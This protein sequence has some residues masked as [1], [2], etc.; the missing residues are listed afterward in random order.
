MPRSLASKL[1]ALV[2]AAT[3]AG[4][5]AVAP[6]VAR[7]AAA[8]DC[9]TYYCATAFVLFSGNGTGH[10]V[11]D[12]G[13]IDCYKTGPSST[14]GTCTYQ[15]YWIGQSS[16]RLA[17]NFTRTATANSE[18]CY[19][20]TTT[21]GEPGGSNTIP[22]SLARNDY[23]SVPTTFALANVMTMNVTLTGD[24][25]GTATSSPSGINCHLASGTMSG[26]C[27][28]TWYF[29]DSFGVSVTK[30]PAD[31]SSACQQSTGGLS[32]AAVG[33]NVTSS[34]STGGSVTVNPVYT[35]LLGH[36]ILTVAVSGAGT[37]VSTPSGISCGSACSSYFP[38][39]SNVTLNAAAK[40]GSHFDH[41]TGA[42]S[43]YG[44][45]C[46]LTLGSADVSTT[47]VFAPNATPGPSPGTTP[48][49]T[50]A[51]TR[52]PGPG[53]SPLPT[54]S[55]APHSSFPTPASPGPGTA[56]PAATVIPASPVAIEASTAPGSEPSADAAGSSP[57]STTPPS[58]SSAP[59]T[60]PVPLDATPGGADSGSSALPWIVVLAGALLILMAGVLVGVV[61]SRRRFG[62]AR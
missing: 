33:D 34:F 36:P 44:A 16:E 25:E 6:P 56:S 21:C 11:D 43:A 12:Q 55:P 48:A 59:S 10:V 5:T 60:S 52:T 14:A 49:P 29:K 47:A 15:Y 18:W 19:Y 8:I 2:V 61:A 23:S 30:D 50:S 17:V 40:A 22:I 51:P 9:V 4:L 31:G 58:G 32:C 62:A 35:F 37:V 26:T 42:C 28:A 53:A 54:R 13:G 41:W 3:L 46:N 1:R 27:S 20:N 24:G 39:S 38:P 45:A 7:P 57:S